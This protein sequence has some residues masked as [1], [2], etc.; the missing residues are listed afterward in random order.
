ML[1]NHLKEQVLVL[2]F[3]ECVDFSDF[4][5]SLRVFFYVCIFIMKMLT[6]Q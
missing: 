6:E 4:T 1:N 5:V 2:K 3:N